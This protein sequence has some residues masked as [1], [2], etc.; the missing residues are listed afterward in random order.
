MD[1]LAIALLAAAGGV[2]LLLALMVAISRWA[3]RSGRAC[4]EELGIEFERTSAAVSLGV[5]SAGRL[6]VR[7]N[8]QLA[9]A[10]DQLVFLQLVP[11]RQVS[12]PLAAIV[13]V[14]TTRAHLGK[15]VGRKLLRVSWTT[16]AGEDA[17]A[18]Q[19]PDL[20]GWLSALGEAT[21]RATDRAPASADRP[22][23]T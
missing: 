11:R 12:I 1:P 5:S 6:Q 2:V 7:G 3:Q 9:L 16:P 20:S 21:A 23:L 4:V 22:R 17:I 10:R 18:L 19:V 15:T 8:G 14:D 13:K